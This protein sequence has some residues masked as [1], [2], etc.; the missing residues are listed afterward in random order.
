MLPPMITIIAG[1]NRNGSN[2]LSVA[3]L[4]QKIYQHH[5]AE[6]RLLDL[7]EMPPEAFHPEA[8]ETLPP[9]YEAAFVEP[10]LQADGLVVVAPEY[11]G[12]FPGILK[13]FID[14][15]PFPEA[16][17]R[18]PV[19]FVGVSSGRYGGLRAIEQLQ[20][21]FGHRNSY[22]F[23]L[24]VFIPAVS[25]AVDSYGQISDVDISKRLEEQ[26]QGFLHFTKIIRAT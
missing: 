20:M 26:A 13:H 6:T 3:R 21:V 17:E 8:F 9:G 24:R 25:R 19:A 11:N 23:N 5:E 14:L 18:R 7:R 2:S 16:F 1:T 22:L 15:L 12:S 4:L 10:V